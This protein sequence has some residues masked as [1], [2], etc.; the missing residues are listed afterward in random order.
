MSQL[1]P[2]YTKCA[3]EGATCPVTGIESVAYSAID[4]AG[5]IYYRNTNK[6]LVCNDIPYGGDPAPNHVKQC[7]SMTIPS[8]IAN[9]SATFFDATGNPNGWTKCASEN[10][11]C[12]PNVSEPVDI[13]FGAQKSFVYA[14]ANQT[15]CSSRIFGDPKIDVVKGCYWRKP[16]IP[17]V[18]VTPGLSPIIPVTPSPV[19]S[20]NKTLKFTLIG[21]GSI[22]LLVIIILIIYVII[23]RSKK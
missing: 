15:P 16:G 6:S 8:D 21:I 5:G 7:S 13:L 4:G 10:Q 1:S 14:N 18:P 17:L 3:S 19:P 2:T 12:N 11:I 22:I 20:S 9:P 23:K